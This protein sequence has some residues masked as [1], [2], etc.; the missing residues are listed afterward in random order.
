MIRRTPRSTL[1]FTLFPYTT[2][3]RASLNS[4][5][6]G[7]AGVHV[8]DA[9]RRGLMALA[10]SNTPAAIAP[11]GGAKALYG[12]NPIAFACPRTG[13]A[14]GTPRPPLV[15]DLSVSTVAR[16]K[17]VLADKEIGRATCRERVCQYV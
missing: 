4:H 17:V 1:T 12:T 13:G 6:F 3:F 7:V 14:D 10:C 16:G 2:L 9:A 5:H 8:E 15:I 11:W